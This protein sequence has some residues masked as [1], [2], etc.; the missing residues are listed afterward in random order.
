[1]QVCNGLSTRLAALAAVMLLVGCATHPVVP[2][3]VYVEVPVY[4]VDE[5]KIPAQ[6]DLLTTQIKADS[7][8][9][10]VAYAYK[11]SLINY[12]GDDAQLRNLL[13][14][15]IKPTSSKAPGSAPSGK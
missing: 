1:M 2:K 15:C 14:A 9:I 13:N 7:T 11:I 8:D 12:L 3:T 10:F 6:P 5:S 4:C